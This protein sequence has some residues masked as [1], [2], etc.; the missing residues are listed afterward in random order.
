MIIKFK[1]LHPEAKA[2]VRAHDG[3]AGWDLTACDF[4]HSEDVTKFHTGIAV[5]IPPGFFGLL[6][7]RSSMSKTCYAMASS[8]VIDAGYRGEI[9]IPLREIGGGCSTYKIGDR[10]CQ[11]VILPLPEVEFVEAEELSAS[12][13]GT[14]GFGSTGK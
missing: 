9:S 6:R 4:D 12:Q 11:L 2:P 14:G 8:G 5:E 7:P 10:I 13:R 3:D 1:R